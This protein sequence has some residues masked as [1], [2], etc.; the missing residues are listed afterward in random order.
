MTQNCKINVLKQ[1]DLV[2]LTPRSVRK[3]NSAQQK[4]YWR[5][6]HQILF[7]IV[8]DF[9]V[10]KNQHSTPWWKERQHLGGWCLKTYRLS[11][12]SYQNCVKKIQLTRRHIETTLIKFYLVTFFLFQCVHKSTYYPMMER[13]A[14][15]GRLMLENI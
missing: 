13:K 10:S 5:H 11:R 7:S 1:I 6:T 12:L 3:K 9:S 8:F 14:K 4:D 15:F 2:V